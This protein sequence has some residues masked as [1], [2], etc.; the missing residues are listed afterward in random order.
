MRS[1]SYSPYQRSARGALP[2]R[3]P[4]DALDFLR[5]HDKMAALMPAVTRMAALQ[6]DCAAALPAMFDACAILQFESGQLVLSTPNAALAAKLKQQ[7]PKLQGIL[8]KRGWQVDA[9][10]L[11]VLFLPALKKSQP[12]KQLTLPQQARSALAMLADTLESSP[13]NAALKAALDAMARRGR[14]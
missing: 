9:I 4:Q 11:K 10:R 6:A 13:R 1:P 12:V 2:A 14:D 5:A 7:L 8:L 3:T